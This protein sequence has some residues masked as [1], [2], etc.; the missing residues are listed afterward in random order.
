MKNHS[1][2]NLLL[3]LSSLTLLSC[4]NDNDPNI[5][6]FRDS[7]AW[8]TAEEL[9]AVH[10]DNLPEPTQLN[11]EMNTDTFWFNEGYSF[12]QNCSS[13]DVLTANA[14]TYF[15]YFKTNY[16]NKFGIAKSYAYADDTTLYNIIKKDNLDSYYDTNPCPAYKFYYVNDLTKG[17]DGFLLKDAVY[18]FEILYDL[19]T[20]TNNYQLKIFIEKAHSNHS[21]TFI[22]KYNL[23]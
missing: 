20:T 4:G 23:K 7:K 9:S 17:D 10:L 6:D 8:F 15:N 11:G 14:T 12:S 21:G 13:V 3:L 2:L 1:C 18:T 16:A 5:K 22:F 19:N